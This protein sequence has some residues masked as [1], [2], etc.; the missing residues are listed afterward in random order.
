MRISTATANNLSLI[1]TF[2]LLSFH[3]PAQLNFCLNRW[4]YLGMPV[5]ADTASDACSLSSDFQDRC[6]LSA[7]HMLV[8]RDHLS[9][10]MHAHPRFPSRSAGMHNRLAPSKGVPALVKPVC[11]A[12]RLSATSRAADLQEMHIAEGSI[13]RRHKCTCWVWPACAAENLITTETKR[14]LK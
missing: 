3:P 11:R 13:L 9:E 10:R 4:I 7:G 14:T 12:P 8:S 5:A 2:L 6:L 1:H